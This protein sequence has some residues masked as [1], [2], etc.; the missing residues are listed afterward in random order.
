MRNCCV[1]HTNNHKALV[2]K[3]IEEVIEVEGLRRGRTTL[4]CLFSLISHLLLCFQN[5]LICF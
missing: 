2:K 4:I 3:I 5:V 1:F